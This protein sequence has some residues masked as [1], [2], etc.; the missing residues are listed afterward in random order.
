MLAIVA[1]LSV[2]MSM[3]LTSLIAMTLRQSVFMPLPF[4]DPDRVVTVMA[5]G[6]ADCQYCPDYLSNDVLDLWRPRVPGLASVGLFREGDFVRDEEGASTRDHAVLIRGDFFKALEMIAKAGRLPDANELGSGDQSGAVVSERYLSRLGWGSAPAAIGRHLI[7]NGRVL[8]VV[9]VVPAGL[10][11]PADGD[12]WVSDRAFPIPGGPEPRLYTAIGRLSHGATLDRVRSELQDAGIGSATVTGEGFRASPAVTP[13]A[14]FL[15]RYPG[16]AIALLV[17]AALVAFLLAAVNLQT[18]LIVRSI[19]NAGATAIRVALGATRTDLLATMAA[20][21]GLLTV[22]GTVVGIGMA[23]VG[24]AVLAPY[25]ATLWG[26]PVLLT[27]DAFSWAGTAISMVLLAGTGLIGPALYSATIDIRQSLQEQSATTTATRRAAR[28]R[29]AFVVVELAIAVLL[30]AGAGL[31][32]RAYGTVT[33]LNL[34]YDPAHLVT[35]QLDLSGSSTA[36]WPGAHQLATEILHITGGRDNSQGAFWIATSPSLAVGPRDQWTVVDGRP[37]PTGIHRLQT[38]YHISQGFF[39]LLQ[40]KATQGRLFDSGDRFGSSPV[41][42]VNQEA[43]AAWWPGENPVGRRIKL[44]PEAGLL[45]WLTVVGVVPNTQQIDAFGLGL[46]SSRPNWKWPLAFLPFDQSTLDARGTPLPVSSLFVATAATNRPQQDVQVLR[47]AAI[48]VAGLQT[49]TSVALLSEIQREGSMY[50]QVLFSGRLL[51]SFASFALLLAGIGLFG[52]LSEG[53]RART[54][55]IGIRRALGAP[56]RSIAVL[57]ARPALLAVGAGLASG[58][59]VASAFR[60][61]L[62]SL[63]FGITPQNPFGLLLS[64]SPQDPIALGAAG[65]WLVSVT[66]LAIAAPLRKAVTINPM[67]AI[68]HR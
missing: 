53:I 8:V 63:F 47:K 2:A 68:R 16:T 38:A 30:V 5:S 7:G 4:P 45:P 15:R 33:H 12:L 22:T 17:G 21:S 57:V 13:L 19:E 62:L 42:I 49:I 37:A 61:P 32:V 29:T 55:E 60:T 28:L 20:E 66:V 46:V 41:V 1:S 59:I 56:S 35:A 25:L 11:F 39:G 34:G 3:A 27:L 64:I 23:L 9:G 6:S 65:A 48:D 24:R 58:W 31:L 52:V 26:R 51:A 36:S 54:P 10:E 44:G 67:L 40:L 14:D 43:A 18:L 50:P